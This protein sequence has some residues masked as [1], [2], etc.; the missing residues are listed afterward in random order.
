MQPDQASSGFRQRWLP[1]VKPK[2]ELVG[3]ILV[4]HRRIGGPN[5]E[6][7]EQKLRERAYKIWEDGGRIDGSHEDDWRRAEEQH[8]ETEREAAE[9]TE[10][11][12]QASEK[13]RD[14]GNEDRSA[15]DIRPPSTVAPD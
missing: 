14:G 8:Q 1:P 2:P 10:A 11:N 3:Q 5:M 9:V 13:F 12:K 4:I 15:A 7:R 6:D